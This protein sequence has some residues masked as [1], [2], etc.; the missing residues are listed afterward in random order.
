MAT[1]V[2]AVFGTGSKSIQSAIAEARQRGMVFDATYG[3]RT[4]SAILTD[5]GHLILCA[6][7]AKTAARRCAGL[8]ENA[9]D[10]VEDDVEDDA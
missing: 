4:R 3:R 6:L 10:D 8:P 7:H 1:R 5:T 9:L 2:V